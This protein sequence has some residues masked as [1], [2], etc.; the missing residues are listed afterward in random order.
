MIAA[1][2][3]CARPFSTRT[4]LGADVIAFNIPA[5]GVQTIYVL[6]ELPHLIERAT[7]DGTTQPGYAGAPLIELY[8]GAERMFGLY[9]EPTSNSSIIRGLV[10]DRFARDAIRVRS[11]GVTISDNYIGTTADGAAP[12]GNSE[13]AVTML[14]AAN[15]TIA[16]NLLVSSSP[17]GIA[18]V[19]ST[20][21]R[22]VGNLIGANA[23]G[24]AQLGDFNLVEYSDSS[25]TVIGGS[26]A[27]EGNVFVG[28]M[29]LLGVGTV[30][31]GNYIGT[32]ITGS[33]PLGTGPI[34]NGGAGH[35]IGGTAAAERNVIAT[36]IVFTH[37]AGGHA[38]L[39]NSIGLHA[40]GV[41]P[42]GY[43]IGVIDTPNVAIGGIAP[44][45]GNTI[46]GAISGVVVQGQSSG[47][48]IRGN[49]MSSVGKGIYVISNR[50]TS[51]L[52]TRVLPGKNEMGVSG[53]LDS[54]PSSTLAI[55]IYSAGCSTQGSYG[56]Q[57]LATTTVTTDAAGHAAFNVN[58]PG[59]QPN[60][61][62][63][64]TNATNDTSEFSP[65]AGPFR[66]RAARP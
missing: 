21:T 33:V 48:V 4:P 27:A 41:T 17:D 22:I 26:T 57:W 28:R 25:G 23:S 15:T 45:A 19:S 32:D 54:M 6:S 56:T 43:G 11:N 5:P 36:G 55:D 38:V 59:I 10:L 3:R 49:S 42:I 64:A 14:G 44:G 12:A 52:I 29:D 58:V 13:A 7:V 24:T 39:G 47:V 65:C 35:V 20:G 30:V 31:R 1:P 9:I 37:G 66:R 16:H 51:P 34:T 18:I 62:A 8:G 40:D 61:T 50:Q 53:V 60:V 46:V 63:T 2:V